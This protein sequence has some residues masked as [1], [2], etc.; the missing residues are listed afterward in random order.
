MRAY[1]PGLIAERRAASN[2]ATST[3]VLSR[4]LRT[5]LPAELGW[6]EDR[7]LS[8]VMGLL[9]GAVETS[10]QAITQALDQF[11]QRPAALAQAAAAAQAGDD[12]TFDALVWEVL[13]F[14]PINPFVPRVAVTEV[15]IGDGGDHATAITAG[16]LTLVGTRSAMQDGAVVTDPQQIKLHRPPWCYMHFGQ[17]PHECLGKYVG[18]MLIPATLQ[19]L[20]TL[21][22][23]RRAPGAAGQLDRAGGPFPE[24]LTVQFG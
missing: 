2:L 17:G 19:H 14:N 9:V 18:M 8:N 6:N 15:V 4:L 7:L 11:L 22:A 5:H 21:P 1:L 3:D 13:R 24:S 16:A 12:A 20:L 23:L 10:N